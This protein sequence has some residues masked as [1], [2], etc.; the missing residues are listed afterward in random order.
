MTPDT[1]DDRVDDLRQQLRA[2]GYLDAGVDRFVLAPARGARGPFIIAVLSSLRIGLLG[3]LL[4]GPAAAV[5]VRSRLPDLVTGLRDA[6][7][8]A[9]YL[10]VLFGAALFVLS[11][12]ASLIAAASVRPSSARFTVRARRF[13]LGAGGAI[14]IALLAYLTLW[15]RTATA[16]F[17]WGAP[18]WTSLTLVAAVAI[19]LLLG[20][21]VMTA[22]LATLAAAAPA[23]PLPRLPSPSWR[24]RI[25]GFAVAFAG[26]AALFLWTAPG[27]AA[28][29]ET[30][31]LTVVPTGVRV[32]V[33]AVDGF[34]AALFREMSARGALP[35]L[36]AALDGARAE[37]IAE[38]TR[39]P[40]RAWTTIAT[41]E[42]PAI[43]GVRG[44]ETRRV[45]GVQGSVDARTAGAIG[46]LIGG[47]TD[48]LRLTRPAVVTRGERHAKTF[49]EVAT[50]AGLRTTVV[51]WWASW[52][53][54]DTGA[55]I[56]TDRA[57]LRLE[58]GGALDAEIAPTSL[59]PALRE[60]WPALRARARSVATEAFG[61][62]DADEIRDILERSAELD[63]SML[64]L[65][66]AL[67]GPPADLTAVYLPGLDIAQHA[68]FSREGGAAL[69][70]SAAASRLDAVRAY[71]SFLDRALRDPLSSDPDECLVIIMEPGR[72]DVAGRGLMALGGRCAAPNARVEA[73][74]IDAAPTILVAL[75]VPLSRELRGTPVAALFSRPF[76]DA[77]PV[78]YVASY[79]SPSA[80]RQVR[81][82]QPLDEEMIE[83]LRS[84]GYVR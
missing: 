36:T 46:R 51:N 3:A 56:L 73:H 75:G 59:Y 48:L 71:Y 18:G 79:G 4:L 64:A 11:L 72:V 19:S 40:A 41:G 12:G 81:R 24:L 43:H 16:G 49:W 58:R 67:P 62:V 45:A 78:R 34:D 44:L 32:R 7:V 25:A 8:V 31:P 22:M 52:P 63:T 61:D 35:A 17:G 65:A 53:A 29:R 60:L 82:G 68:L 84:L 76:V 69:S 38:D 55:T 83:R 6:I 20:H 39:D 74:A 14:A 2:L 70:P 37:L 13:A 28:G 77:H 27:V 1:R 66:A 42:P 57:V 50:D 54:P 33:I 80:V 21:A 23:S 47:A 15:W 26:A 30:P 5:G 10:G 9:I